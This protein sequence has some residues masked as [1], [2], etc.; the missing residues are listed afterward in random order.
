MT[1]RTLFFSLFC[2][3]LS[4]TAVA[5]RSDTPLYPQE[6]EPLVVQQQNTL[7]AQ[8]RSAVKQVRQLNGAKGGLYSMWTDGKDY[9]MLES[10]SDNSRYV[11]GKASE[12]DNTKPQLTYN[13]T[14]DLSVKGMK[15]GVTRA[16]FCTFNDIEMLL[17]LDTKGR[18]C[19]L[20]LSNVFMHRRDYTE[21]QVC[22]LWYDGLYLSEDSIYAVVG[23]RRDHYQVAGD[24][25]DPGCF[26][27]EAIP[28]DTSRYTHTGYYGEG[29]I[30][31]GDP[32]APGYDEKMPGGGGAGAL[33][34]TMVWQVAPSADGMDV[35]VVEDQPSSRHHPYFPKGQHHFRRIATPFADVKGQ[36]PLTA[37]LPLPTA[38]LR[39]LPAETLQQMREEL[40]TRNGGKSAKLT[41]IETINLQLIEAYL[42]RR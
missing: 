14:A 35:V 30:S 18:A 26:V 22:H 24:V 41:A 6:L 27:V 23:P 2:I 4:G 25:Q 8:R 12:D 19:D 31:R 13:G 33:A 5:Q 10:P 37:I 36:W 7:Q 20:Y 34:G 17:F 40:Y 9:Y 1:H 39:R 38:F 32:Q 42:R 11:F 3:L 21:S 15:G 28:G 29:R 16:R